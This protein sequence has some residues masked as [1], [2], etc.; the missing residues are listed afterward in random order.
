MKLKA[1]PLISVECWGGIA[2]MV[3]SFLNPFALPLHLQMH[4]GQKHIG[5]TSHQT[6]TPGE[7]MIVMAI[8][9]ALSSFDKIKLY[10]F[11]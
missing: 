10:H 1:S 7:Q 4:Q 3:G 9:F 11:D 6:G 8:H 5:N 2:L